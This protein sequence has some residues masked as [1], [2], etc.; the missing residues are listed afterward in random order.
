[1]SS[2][3][4]HIYR[5]IRIITTP[6]VKVYHGY[7]DEDLMLVFGHVFKR[8]PMP[9][10]YYKKN[11]WSNTISLIRMFMAKPYPNAKVQLEWYGQTIEAETDTDGFFKLEWKSETLP[12]DGWHEIRVKLLMDAPEPVYGE[13]KILVP[14]PTKYAYV[15]DVDDTFLVSHSS[16]LWRRLYVLLTK[17]PRTRKPFEGVVNHYQLLAQSNTSEQTPNPFFYVSS[18]E[19]NLYEYLKEFCR[20]YK[21][22]EG[23]Y[24]LSQV[25]QWYQFLAT[26]RGKHSGKFMRIARLLKEFPHRQFVL[27]GDDTQQDPFIYTA[28]VDAFPGRIACIYLRHVRKSRKKQVEALAEGNKRKGTEVCYYTHSKNAI[29]HS[30]RMGYIDEKYQKSV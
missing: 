27:L 26:G 8:S 5:W 22:P 29:A 2:I 9:K 4:E 25:K 14:H 7:G 6:V 15:S 23:V 16:K 21:L 13:G 11:I 18:S 19:W 20:F 28:L 17:N 30:L 3:K 10:H 24:L 12:K 1:M